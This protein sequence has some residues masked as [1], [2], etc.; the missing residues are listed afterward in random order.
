MN[1]LSIR[2]LDDRSMAE[3]KRRAAQDDASL[4]TMVLRLIEQGLGVRST[5]PALRR[6]TDLD[7][8]VGSWSKAEFTA[9]E[10]ATA[11]F[12]EVDAGLWK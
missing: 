7:A 6:H 9:F 12:N 4:N 10:Q 11:A 3:L 2:G 5:K 8:L 1:N